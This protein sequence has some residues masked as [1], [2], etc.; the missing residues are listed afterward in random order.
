[1]NR[2]ELQKRLGELRIAER[3][4]IHNLGFIVGRIEELKQVLDNLSEKPTVIRGGKKA[5]A[6]IKADKAEKR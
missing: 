4:A 6:A 1:M 2:D 3:E 5:E